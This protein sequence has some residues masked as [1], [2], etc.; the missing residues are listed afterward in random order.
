MRAPGTREKAPESLI[1]RSPQ[2]RVAAS[3]QRLVHLGPVLCQ[4]L[5][6]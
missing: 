5:R 2:I 6:S 4:R 3:M 1:L